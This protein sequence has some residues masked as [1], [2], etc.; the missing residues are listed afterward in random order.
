MVEIRQAQ[1]AVAGRLREV[2]LAWERSP[3]NR[4]AMIGQPADRRPAPGSYR[5]SR[6]PGTRSAWLS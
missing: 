4:P 1:H 2:S 3:L 5:E 6:F